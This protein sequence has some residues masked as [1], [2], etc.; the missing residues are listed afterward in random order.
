[1]S[2]LE[3]DLWWKRQFARLL[4]FE[5]DGSPTRN[6][7]RRWLLLASRTW[8]DRRWAVSFDVPDHIYHI[9]CDADVRAKDHGYARQ[10]WAEAR[11]WLSA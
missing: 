10:Q 8:G 1:M 7:E 4:A 3:R 9:I 11:E 2:A 6:V 5:Q